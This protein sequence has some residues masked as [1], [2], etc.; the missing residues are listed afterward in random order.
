MGLFSRKDRADAGPP[1]WKRAALRALPWKGRRIDAEALEELEGVLIQSDFGVQAS[2]KL[3]GLL[4]ARAK[5]EGLSEMSQLREALRDAVEALFSGLPEDG[6]S[7]ADSAPTVYLMVGV[8]GAGK[9][10]TIA[11][12]AHRLVEDGLSVMVAAGDTYRA[13]AT[14]QLSVWADRV[15]ADFVAGQPGADPAAVAFDALGAALA[16]G[17]DVVLID[18]AGRLHTHGG[19]M[20]ELI[21]VKR[22]IGKR[23]PGAPHEVL[24]V[25][26]ATVGQNGLIQAREFNKAVDVTGVILAKMDSTA[27][28]GIAVALTE[29]LGIPIRLV[30]VG[31]GAEDLVPFDPEDFSRGVLDTT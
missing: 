27:K 11:K 7:V 22:V 2:V 31:E 24:Q 21:K 13:G 19:L 12:I 3:V 30:G 28:G 18:T 15:G 20:Q 10:T 4:E 26:D 1:I 17:T 25:L 6:L 16:R 23:V 29:E 14:E 9:T 8:N 5:K